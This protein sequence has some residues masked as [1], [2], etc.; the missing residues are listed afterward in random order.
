MRS[1][2][3]SVPD[4]DDEPLYSMYFTHNDTKK[5]CTFYIGIFHSLQIPIV[6]G[7]VCA[8]RER[9]GGGKGQVGKETN[10]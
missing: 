9:K 5:P 1:N 6:C 3:L 8:L 10:I 7:F 4:D 2:N